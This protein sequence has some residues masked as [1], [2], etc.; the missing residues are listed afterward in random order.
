MTTPT[1]AEV[2]QKLWDLGNQPY[3]IWQSLRKAGVKGQRGLSND[4]PIANYLRKEFDVP[5]VRIQY[6]RGAINP[7]FWQ[8]ARSATRYINSWVDFELPGP[9]RDFIA[10]F[11]TGSYPSLRGE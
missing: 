11:D 8:T 10:A 9:V 6:M 1:A 4:C 7:V 2:E 5:T 3:R